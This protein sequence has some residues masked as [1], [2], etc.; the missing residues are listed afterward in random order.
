MFGDGT[1]ALGLASVAQLLA[2]RS[3]E[4]T[5]AAFTAHSS[6]MPAWKIT[7]IPLSKGGNFYVKSVKVRTV[8]YVGNID[9]VDTNCA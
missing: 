8:Q 2:N 4:E 7:H 5:L 6:I 1:L 3:L 9:G